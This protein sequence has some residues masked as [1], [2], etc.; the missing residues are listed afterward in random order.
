VSTIKHKTGTPAFKFAD[1][2]LAQLGRIEAIFECPKRVVENAY[3]YA[4]AEAVMPM[5]VSA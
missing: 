2:C 4:F 5:G 3:Y 1:G